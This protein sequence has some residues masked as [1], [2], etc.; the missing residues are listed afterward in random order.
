MPQAVNQTYIFVPMMVVVLLTFFAFM[1]MGAA[2]G[3]AMKEGQDPNFYRAH[4]GPPEPEYATVATRHYGNMFEM[5]TLFYAACITAF[6]L[7][8]VGFWTVLFAWGYVF[9]RLVQSAVHL[10]S[11]NPSYRGLGFVLSVLFLLAMWVDIAIVVFA[12]L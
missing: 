2:R 10:T 7:T 9:G 1:R 12:R 5:P 6:V 8:A 3:R 11:N 4:L